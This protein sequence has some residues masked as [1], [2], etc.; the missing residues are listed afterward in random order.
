MSRLSHQSTFD[1]VGRGTLSIL[2]FPQVIE[3]SPLRA[4]SILKIGRL[5]KMPLWALTTHRALLRMNLDAIMNKR[6]VS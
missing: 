1:F 4:G 2:L 5:S 6:R 3:R